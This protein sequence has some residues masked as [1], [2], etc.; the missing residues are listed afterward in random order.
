M[1]QSKSPL[2][3]GAAEAWPFCFCRVSPVVPVILHYIWSAKPAQ[4][5]DI[6]SSV[7]RFT[8]SSADHQA[9]LSWYSQQDQNIS[10]L[11]VKAPQL[12][13]HCS[14]SPQVKKSF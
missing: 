6:S 8:P 13:T 9:Q 14:K 2:S 3:K 1:T 12:V 7:S 11:P 10:S 4:Y 5:R